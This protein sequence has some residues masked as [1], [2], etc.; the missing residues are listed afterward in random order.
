MGNSALITNTVNSG[1][2]GIGSNALLN[3]D[4]T[5]NTAIGFDAGSSITTGSYNTFLGA[6]VDSNAGARTGAIAIGVDSAAVAASAITDNGLFFH[7]SL[8]VVV[9]TAVN[10]N[11]TTGAM[12]PVV[13]SRRFK[14]NI[15]AL[16]LDSSKVFDLRPVSYDWNL[17]QLKGHMR[18]FGLIAEEVAEIFPELVPRDA[19]GLPCSV[20]YDRISVLL[21]EEL[22]KVRDVVAAQ[23]SKITEL[24]TALANLKQRLL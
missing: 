2:T 16:E 4:A 18:D 12:G 22:R 1:N 5:H 3:A 14:D 23:A 6:A 20:N 8:A 15:Q 9:A 24:G 10:Y 7:K 21:L 11:A 17:P 19:G 13:S